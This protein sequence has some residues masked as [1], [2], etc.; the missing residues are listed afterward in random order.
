[1]NQHTPR[2]E[3]FIDSIHGYVGTHNGQGRF[4]F[5][6]SDVVPG[7]IIDILDIDEKVAI[8]LIE[9]GDQSS[10][11][12]HRLTE[13]SLEAHENGYTLYHVFESD[14]L[15]HRDV[16]HKK[17]DAL[18]TLNMEHKKVYR[19]YKCRISRIDEATYMG[20]SREYSMSHGGKADKYFGMRPLDPLD[21]TLLAVVGVKKVKRDNG[22]LMM[23]AYITNLDKKVVGSFGQFIA[24]IKHLKPRCIYQADLRWLNLRSDFI[25]KSGMRLVR[26]T[27][28]AKYAFSQGVKRL[29]RLDHMT[30]DVFATRVRTYVP[31]DFK[32]TLEDN[33]IAN[34]Y[35]FV[36]DAGQMVFTTT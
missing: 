22:C 23:T 15:H 21:D 33:L 31:Y 3:N 20:F 34:D 28:P 19:A 32:K 17:M 26:V 11:N 2:R 14:W 35:S 10:Q 4:E 18:L 12:R 8:N 24:Y 7:K 9:L 30:G 6:S 36:H 1:M 13:M 27:P 5:F 16:L 25:V 29:Y